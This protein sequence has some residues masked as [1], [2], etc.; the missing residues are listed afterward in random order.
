[1]NLDQQLI[2]AARTGKTQEAEELLN[3]GADIHKRWD[4]ALRFAAG[5]GHT[6]TV[7][8]LMEHGADIHAEKDYALRYATEFGHTETAKVLISHYKTSE[9]KEFLGKKEFPQ[10]LLQKEIETRNTKLAQKAKRTE[11][12]IEI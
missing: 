6:K 7:Q 3:S 12:Q 10:D 9:L 1:M 8:L 4:E 5:N 11:P 2:E